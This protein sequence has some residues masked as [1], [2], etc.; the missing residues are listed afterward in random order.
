MPA[1]SSDIYNL[2]NFIVISNHLALNLRIDY[3]LLFPEHL[4]MYCVSLSNAE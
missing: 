1:N 3:L 2:H 4:G